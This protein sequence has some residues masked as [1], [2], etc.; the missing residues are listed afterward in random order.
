MAAQERAELIADLERRLR[1]LQG[2]PSPSSPQSNEDSPSSS[3]P[4]PTTRPRLTNPTTAAFDSILGEGITYANFSQARI[5]YRPTTCSWPWTSPTELD[6]QAWVTLICDQVDPARPGFISHTTRHRV[7][8][9]TSLGT[10]LL[11]IVPEGNTMLILRVMTSSGS[12]GLGAH[13][14][15]FTNTVAQIACFPVGTRPAGI[16]TM[17]AHRTPG[18]TTA[19]TRARSRSP[20]GM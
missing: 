15:L 13:Q 1:R 6:L 16:T 20:A 3:S 12:T 18:S 11:T 17:A 19:S 7:V 5:H 10:A 4:A 14:Q 8:P 2:I 9:G